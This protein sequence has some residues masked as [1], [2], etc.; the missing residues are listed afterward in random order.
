LE[1]K[2]QET[3]DSVIYTEDTTVDINDEG[4]QPIT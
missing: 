2:A 4:E 3:T 1:E